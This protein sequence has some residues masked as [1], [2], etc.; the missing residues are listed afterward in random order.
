MYAYENRT[1]FFTKL[2][3]LTNLNEEMRKVLKFAK[4][5]DI[6]NQFKKQQRLY[7]IHF[8]KPCLL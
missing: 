1:L 7:Y 2:K 5:T 4:R 6:G 8:K 3:I